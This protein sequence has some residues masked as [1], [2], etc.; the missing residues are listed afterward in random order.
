M[1]LEMRHERLA[2]DEEFKA[3]V[4]RFNAKQ[5]LDFHHSAGVE[6]AVWFGN[7]GWKWLYSAYTVDGHRTLIA[8]YSDKAL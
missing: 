8:Y 5:I 7:G 3:A 1:R 6:G 2:T 4:K